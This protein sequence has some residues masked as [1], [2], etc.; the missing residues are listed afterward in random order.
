[1]YIG[2]LVGRL[3]SVELA[4]CGCSDMDSNNEEYR[5]LQRRFSLIYTISTMCAEECPSCLKSAIE[6]IYARLLRM[7]DLSCQLTTVEV[8][9]SNDR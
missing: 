3:E 4:L 8:L 6:R 2:E 1:M 9:V 5:E 7:P